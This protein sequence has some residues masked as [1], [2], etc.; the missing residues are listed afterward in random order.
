MNIAPERVHRLKNQIAI[1]LGFC[2]LLLTDMA[3][4]DPRRADVSRI[5]DAGR[6][7]L[8]ELPPLPA[9]DFSRPEPPTEAKHGD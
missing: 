4:D 9:H 6:N 2:E 5:Q 1:I 7:A 8:A 3:E